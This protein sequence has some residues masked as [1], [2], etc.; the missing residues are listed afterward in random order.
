MVAGEKNTQILIASAALAVACADHCVDLSSNT[1]CRR[2]VLCK[3]VQSPDIVRFNDLAGRLLR[4]ICTPTVTD[5]GPTSVSDRT[6]H[7]KL[8]S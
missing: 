4:A 8:A 3:I 2:S 7:P 1:P 6:S 5:D